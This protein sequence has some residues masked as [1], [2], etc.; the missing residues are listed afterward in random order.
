MIILN[1]ELAIADF[2][3]LIYEF[4]PGEAGTRIFLTLYRRY[5]FLPYCNQISL[6]TVENVQKNR[7]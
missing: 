1:F 5:P 7:Y 3:P 6:L 2:I 4:E